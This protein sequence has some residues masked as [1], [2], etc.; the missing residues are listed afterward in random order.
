MKSDA[1]PSI[2]FE[3]WKGAL[4]PAITV[5]VLG[6]IGFGLTRGRAGAI[7]SLLANFIVVIFFAIHLA[8]SKVSA[9]MDPMLTMMLAMFSYFGKM[10]ILGAFLLLVV[11]KI[12][13]DTLDRL[14][15]GVVAIAITFAWLAGEIRAFLKLRLTL[16]M[17]KN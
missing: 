10:L 16:P 9:K 17:P 5:G 12:A 11:K 1:K 8:I 6:I 4:L 7:G 13:P 2:E 3:M 15:F 14:S